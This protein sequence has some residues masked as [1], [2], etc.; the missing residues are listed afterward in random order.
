MDGGVRPF[1]SAKS[2]R[3]PSSFDHIASRPV[4]IN[5]TFDNCAMSRG[6]AGVCVNA[7]TGATTSI[8]ATAATGATTSTTASAATAALSPRLTLAR[9]IQRTQSVV[10][11]L[12]ERAWAAQVKVIVA[13][14]QHAFEKLNVDS[15]HGLR[16]NRTA[17]LGGLTVTQMN[18][19]VWVRLLRRS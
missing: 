18:G 10:K 9:D 8:G 1:A 19:Q 16:S 12:H 3:L 5:T 13:E 15:S 17:R 14:R 2:R 4:F 7:T 6:T 11:I